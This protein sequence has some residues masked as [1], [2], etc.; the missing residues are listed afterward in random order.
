MKAGWRAN[1]LLA[2]ILAA[3]AALRFWGLRWGLPNAL[4]SYS[5]HP[6]EFLTLGAAGM[7]LTAVLPR[8]YNYPSL[9]LYIAAAAV[10][11]GYIYGFAPD[12]A[13][14]YL[15]ARVVTALMGVGA[16]A[17]TYWAASCHS[18]RSE[19]S[20]SPPMAGLLAA[21][22]L[23]IAPLHVQHS[24]FATVDVPS[25]LFVAACLGFAGLVLN[26]GSWRDYILCGVMAGLAAGTK[27]N[28]GLVIL[29]LI[30][31]HVFRDLSGALSILSLSKERRC[32]AEIPKLVAGMG[33]AIAAFV[34]STPG[35]ILQ[36]NTFKHGFLYE[37]VH[38]MTGHGLVFAGTG[39]GF[40]YTFT[41]S[42]WYGLGPALATLFAVAAIYGLVR[43]DR[44][45]LTILAFAL[46]Y[47]AL[48]SLSQVRFARYS[49]PLFPAAALL[50]AWMACDVWRRFSPE[51]AEPVEARRIRPTIRQATFLVLRWAWAGLL[52]IV[53]IGTLLYTIALDR[54][55]VLPPPQDRAARWIF[56]N[57]PKGSRIG[58]FDVPWFYSPPYTK[59]TGAGTLQQ[60]VEA[61]AKTPYKLQPIL[62]PA[63]MA[64]VWKPAH[65]IVVSDY[66]ILDALRLSGSTSVPD[67]TDEWQVR[68]T[69]AGL[70]V[71]RRYYTI[72]RTFSDPLSA[73]G[74]SFGSTQSLPHDMRYSAPTIWIYQLKKPSAPQPSQRLSDSQER[75]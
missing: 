66:E 35:V 58:V 56:A 71:V 45:A 32:V 70:S 7:I 75:K 26:R 9:Y 53:L 38:S 57:I 6:D 2:V 52:T 62:S 23:C 54:L 68:C 73:L 33:Y 13:G 12:P 19:E 24:H 31:A 8:F 61:H 64:G 65:W 41:S 74:I 69:V 11:M 27:Y 3:A 5:Y 50:I 18:E 55:F 42:L 36:W 1:L 10:G 72:Q 34:I 20:A 48:I 67:G 15:C 47:Y 14:G 4:H 25:T 40:L 16:V 28:A 63:S 43:L 60:R 30:A 49:L 37:V 22:I 59:D 51:H 29:A 44:R 46:P 39:N 17:V 21:F